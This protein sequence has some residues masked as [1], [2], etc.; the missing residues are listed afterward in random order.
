MK[1][2]LLLLLSIAFLYGCLEEKGNAQTG[3]PNVAVN[4]ANDKG[5]G[6]MYCGGQG[7]KTV[8]IGTQTWMAQNLNYAVEGSV[9]YGEGGK[10]PK[11]YDDKKGANIYAALPSA[12]VQKNC[13]KYGRLYNWATAMALQQSC[14]SSSCASQIKAK[15]QGIC[16]A[17]WHIPSKAEWDMLIKNANNFWKLAAAGWDKFTNQDGQVTGVCECANT[18]GFSALPG[19]N[20]YIATFEEDR[21]GLYFSNVGGAGYWWSSSEYHAGCAYNLEESAFPGP[22]YTCWDSMEDDFGNKGNYFS[23]RCIKD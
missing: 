23:V 21:G 7:Y 15:H 19:G 22:E 17:G 4:P 2:H 12:E 3:C 6:S 20:G 11:G 18:Y 16:P 5:V 13:A 1:N 8:K 9:C 10:I 14:N